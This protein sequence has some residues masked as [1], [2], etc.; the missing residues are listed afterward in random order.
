MITTTTIRFGRKGYGGVDYEPTL[1]I[2]VPWSP[3]FAAAYQQFVN[4]GYGQ[5]G[6]YGGGYEQYG[7]YG[8]GYGQYGGYGGGYGQS[9][10]YGGGYG[11]GLGGYGAS[12]FG[13]G[14]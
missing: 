6:G 1:T 4:S 2:F 11:G 10:G 5:Y 3:E 14:G 8:G 9:G 13:L 7:G 12:P